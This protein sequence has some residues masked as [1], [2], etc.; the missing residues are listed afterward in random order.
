MATSWLSILALGQVGMKSLHGKHVR[1]QVWE[2]VWEAGGA[3][4]AREGAGM[5]AG[6][7]S[8]CGKHVREQEGSE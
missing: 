4:E 6:G 8:R 7:G 2:L 5:R 1:E 3:W